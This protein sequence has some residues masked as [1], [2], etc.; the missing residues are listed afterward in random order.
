MLKKKIGLML[1]LTHMPII[2][3]GSEYLILFK[4]MIHDGLI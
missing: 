1:D 2:E 4:V 3:L